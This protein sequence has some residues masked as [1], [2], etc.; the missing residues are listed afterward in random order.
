M[1]APRIVLQ[2]SIKLLALLV[3]HRHKVV[4]V[5]KDNAL[6]TTIHVLQKYLVQLHALKRLIS[7]EVEF[8]VPC[9]VVK[10]LILA[11]LSVRMFLMEPLV[12]KVETHNPCNALAKLAFLHLRLE[13]AHQQTLVQRVKRVVHF[14]TIATVK[15]LAVKVV[16]EQQHAR[17]L[18]AHSPLVVQVL[19]A[20]LPQLPLEMEWILI[21]GLF[22]NS[23]INIY[24]RILWVDNLFK[25]IIPILLLLQ[26]GF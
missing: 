2:I 11:L 8:V 13:L 3:Q 7:S 10:Q 19:S 1:E 18:F 23:E 6:I 17:L 22:D 21:S 25:S 14:L 26:V 24:N 20:S 16:M 9:G 12:L 4:F 15:Q 5:T